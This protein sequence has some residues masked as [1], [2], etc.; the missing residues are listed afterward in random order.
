MST[1]TKI[2]AFVS[3]ASLTMVLLMVGVWALKTIN[4]T[5]GGNLSY[6]APGI[7]ATIS[8]GTMSNGVWV[9]AGDAS[10]KMPLTQITRTDTEESLEEKFSYWQDLNLNFNERGDDVTITFSITNDMEEKYL[11]INVPTSYESADNATISINTSS[12]ELEPDAS[13]SFTIT[14]K[15]TDKTANATL[16]SFAIVFHMEMAE[17]PKPVDQD[18][19]EYLTF[20]VT[21]ATEKTVS[22]EKSGKGTMP[23]DLVIPAYVDIDGGTYAVTS[24]PD[25]G[26]ESGEAFQNTSMTSITLPDTLSYIG[27]FVFQDS[28]VQ[29]LYVGTG[30]EAISFSAFVG[31]S[32]SYNVYENGN[33][34][35]SK[36]KPYLVLCSINSS[37][38]TS[39]TIHEDCV[40]LMS[41]QGSNDGIF[42]NCTSLESI[43]IPNKIKKIGDSCFN[44]CTGLTS[45]TIPNSVTS[46]GNYAFYGC[47]GLT[48]ITIP[49]SV[50]IIGEFVF[51]GCTG[52]TSITI[53]DKVT[54]IGMN[55]FYNCT[56]LEKVE[57]KAT[58][59]P[60]GGYNMFNNCPLTTGILVPSGSVD[61]YKTAEYWSGY[62][63]YIKAGS[64]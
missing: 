14:M 63:D 36:T 64:F 4:F 37:S 11:S 51:Y 21:D 46:V 19:Y 42:L 17:P 5:V 54:S 53:P 12:A 61:A 20:T 3:L 59:V 52:L 33:Y 50:T 6:I 38:I 31:S 57:V 56:S 29:K 18:D 15:V 8:K 60:T 41:G 43:V 10:T 24:I 7:E 39:F 47:T 58:T 25:A 27:S 26:F 23:T 9:N 28:S 44:G 55:T 62:A 30:L 45:I 48:S 1:K 34:L 40:T 13:Q 35:G 2:M 32:I 22:V 49:N 16:S